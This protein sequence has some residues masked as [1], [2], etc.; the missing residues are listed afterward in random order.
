MSARGRRWTAGLVLGGV[1][2]AAGFLIAQRVSPRGEPGPA[3]IA[4]SQEHGLASPAPSLPR[5]AGPGT[6]AAGSPTASRGEPAPGLAPAP[7]FHPR[8]EGEW[9]GMQV[10]TAAQALCDTSSRC[11][12]GMACHG[13][14]CGPCAADDECAAGEA[15]VLDHCVPRAQVACRSRRDCAGGEELCVLTGYSS[16]PRGNAAMMAKCQPAQGGTPAPAAEPV[17]GVPAPAGESAP[18]ALLDAVRAHARATL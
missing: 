1:L 16:D 2:A 8:D 10:N 9:Q 6:E 17:A 4:L 7:V 18:Q 5:A 15:C 12:L 3:V 11:G 14:T 13:G